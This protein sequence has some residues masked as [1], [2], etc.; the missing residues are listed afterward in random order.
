[1]LYEDAFLHT[2]NN[3]DSIDDTNKNQLKAAAN[4]DTNIGKSLS[5]V[6]ATLPVA[7][8]MPVEPPHLHLWLC[9]I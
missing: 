3:N 1:M 9:L 2:D 4:T 8:L 5:D 7:V 6:Q